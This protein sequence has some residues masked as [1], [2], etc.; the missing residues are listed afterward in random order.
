MGRSLQP[1]LGQVYTCAAGSHIGCRAQRMLPQV[2][3][4]QHLNLNV[5][6]C[7]CSSCHTADTVLVIADG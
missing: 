3:P 2:V 1:L 7:T 6:M 5:W 4:E